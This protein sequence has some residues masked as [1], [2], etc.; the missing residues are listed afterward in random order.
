LTAA[1]KADKASKHKRNMAKSF[2]FV[3]AVRKLGQ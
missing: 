2:D 1:G 3:L